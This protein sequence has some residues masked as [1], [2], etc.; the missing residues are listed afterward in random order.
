MGGGISTLPGGYKSCKDNTCFKVNCSVCDAFK[1]TGVAMSET[2]S[3]NPT[4][5]D[6]LLSFLT[7]S[8]KG[9]GA[10]LRGAERTPGRRWVFWFCYPSQ[11]VMDAGQTGQA[12][13]NPDLV[14]PREAVT[15]VGDKP[16]GGACQGH[17]S[18]PPRCI[19][20]VS[21]GNP[22]NLSE[23]HFPSGRTEGGE[24]STCLTK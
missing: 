2:I 11:H 13:A 7:S 5:R 21:L 23:P 17:E 18:E 19:Y 4:R 8:N 20:C 16:W 3:L 14:S 1:G 10:T 22:H 9:S 12:V 15:G 24:N 6:K